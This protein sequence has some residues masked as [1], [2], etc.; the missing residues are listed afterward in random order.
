[1]LRFS[2]LKTWLCFST[3]SA[4]EADGSRSSRRVDVI[5][6]KKELM[7]SQIWSMVV[8]WARMA[9]MASMV[10]SVALMA[11]RATMGI[12][13][14]AL[15]ALVAGVTALRWSKLGNKLLVYGPEDLLVRGWSYNSGVITV[16][17]ELGQNSSNIWL[18]STTI[19]AVEDDGPR[20][21]R[22]VDDAKVKKELMGCQLWALVGGVEWWRRW[23]ASMDG[24]D[25]WRRWWTGVFDTEGTDVEVPLCPVVSLACAEVACFQ[26]EQLHEN[27]AVLSTC[28]F[29]FLCEGDTLVLLSRSRFVT[30]CCV[31]CS[32]VWASYLCLLFQSW[33]SF[34]MVVYTT[35]VILTAELW[36]V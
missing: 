18:C 24:I 27:C 17:F 1:M 2:P 15:K 30:V 36:C 10:A 23:V 3:K 35:T 14:A 5:K 32:T 29:L 20:C 34:V 28:L 12:A 4:W 16:V 21:S 9:S 13:S 31:S 11:P 6:V 26:S 8:T 33:V 19:M 22:R 7:G 25:G